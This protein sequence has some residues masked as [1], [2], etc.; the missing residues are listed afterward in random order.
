MFQLSDEQVR[1]LL[2]YRG[3]NF[4]AFFFTLVIQEYMGLKYEPFDSHFFVTIISS[5]VLEQSL[6]Q[7]LA[8]K[9][10]ALN[11]KPCTLNPK[12]QTLNPTP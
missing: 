4:F 5:H 6:V 12:P 1:P 8:G 10:E 2:S 3:C 11:P 7:D 9:P